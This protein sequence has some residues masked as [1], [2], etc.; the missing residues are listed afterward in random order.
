MNKI[1]RYAIDL[2]V[3]AIQCHADN[4]E[5]DDGKLSCPGGCDHIGICPDHGYAIDLAWAISELIEAEAGRILVMVL[6]KEDADR[7][8]QADKDR[9]AEEQRKDKERAEKERPK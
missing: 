7:E 4:D 6:N 2:V 3:G 5:D 8:R 9:I 1:E